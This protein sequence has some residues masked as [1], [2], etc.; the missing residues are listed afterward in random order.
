MSHLSLL[1]DDGHLV[2][3]LDVI[4][5][6]FEKDVGNTD[7]VVVLL[8][9]VERVASD[10]RSG[11]LRTPLN[12]QLQAVSMVNIAKALLNFASSLTYI[13]HTYYVY[14][15]SRIKMFVFVTE[16]G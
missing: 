11:L 4:E 8:R 10:R 15:F 3:E 1:A 6:S 5:Q 9:L 12:Q 16:Y 7:Q 13:S 2:V 14:I